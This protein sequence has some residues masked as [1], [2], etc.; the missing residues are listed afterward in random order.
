M[1]FD[2]Y[3]FNN[4]QNDGIPADFNDDT[5]R[6]N[7]TKKVLALVGLQLTMTFG[8]VTSVAI[9]ENAKPMGETLAGKGLF[10]PEL[11]WF[12]IVMTFVLL[13][14]ATCCCSSILRKAPHN[15]G[16]LFLFTVFES[17]LISTVGLR[18]DIG[19]IGSAMGATAGVVLI[20]AALVAF[21]N[22]DFT[23]LLP[24]MFAVL[25]SWILVVIITRLMGVQWDR[26][27]YC[28]IGVTIF[29]IFLAIDLKLVLG[30]GKY[31]YTEDD[32]V[33]ASLNIY[34]DILNIFLYILQMFGD[35]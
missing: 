18:Y 23:K 28:C 33:L 15:F 3:N 8:A 35:N 5:T 31:Q 29:T 2:D 4:D 6:K 17:H 27:L 19:A 13:F 10:T 24:I 7:F 11:L 14:G 32:Y 20:V 26:T 21:T 22:F 12:S 16:F 25:L 30:G 1:G 9:V 34:L